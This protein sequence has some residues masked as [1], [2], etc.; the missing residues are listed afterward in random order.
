MPGIRRLR[1]TRCI[2]CGIE[3]TDAT[4]VLKGDRGWHARCRDCRK[5]ER[6]RQHDEQ[7]ASR[8]LFVTREVCDI[9]LQPERQKRSGIVRL[10]NKDHDHRTGE[11]RGLLCSRCNQAVGLFADNPALLRRAAA[12]LENPPGLVLLDDEPPETRQEWRKYF[13]GGSSRRT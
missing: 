9:C 7:E 1:R 4:G 3:L 8:R 2:D 13:P 12:Y 10:L 11:W 5:S 6:R